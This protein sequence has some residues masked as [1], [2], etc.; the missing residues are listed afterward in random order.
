MFED[1]LYP[2]QASFSHG[3]VSPY[4]FGRVDLQAFGSALRTSRNA[5]IRTEGSWSNRSGT[6]FC[7]PA[8]SATGNGSVIIPFTFNVGQT[9]VIEFGAGTIHLFSQGALINTGT[10]PYAIGDLAKLRYSQSADTLT[11]VHPNYPTYEFKRTDATSFTFLPALYT[12]GPFLQQNPDGVTFVY[13]SAQAGTVTLVASDSIFKAGHVGAL[14]QMTQQD[15]SQIPPWEPTKRMNPLEAGVVAILGQLRRSNGKNYKC[16]GCPNPGAPIAITTGA[17]APDH[18]QGTQSDG[19]GN[20]VANFADAV[21][22]NW[23]YTDSGVGIVLITQF[24]SETQVVG[25]VQA[26]Y[27]GG[28]GLLP[29]AVVGGPQLAV[30]GPWT[31]DG[32]GSTTSFPL[33]TST[34]TDPNLFLVTVGGVYQPPALYSISG[35]N[36]VFLGAPDINVAILVNQITALGQTTYWAFGAFSPDQGYPSAATYYPDRLVLAATP[37]EPVGV[38]ASKT[39]NYHDFGVSNPVVNSDGFTVFLNARQLNAISDLVPLQDIIIGTANI[40]W[41][42]TSGGNGAALGPLAIEAIPQAFLG[43]SPTAAAV[44]YADSMIFAI[45]GGRRIRDLVYQFQFDKY[46]G[47]ELTAYS[48]HLVPFGTQIIKMQ[49]APD[50]WGLLYVLRSDGILLCCTYVREQ[51]MIAWSRWDTQGLVDDIAV[52]PENNNYALYMI[53]RRTINGASVRYV[54]RLSQWETLTP[55]DYQFMDCNLTYDG[56][57]KSAVTM[58]LSGGTTW[59]AGDVGTLNASSATGWAG[60]AA[61]D[62]DLQNQIQLIDAAG[63]CRVQITA[64]LSPA[65]ATVV[66]IDPIPTDLQAVPTL[67]WTFARTKFGGC[68][69]LIGQ[70]VSVVADANAILGQ[71]GVPYIT[72]DSSGFVTL[73]NACGVVC[74][75]LQYYSDLETLALNAQGMETIRQRAKGIPAVYLD[76]TGT[77]GLQTGTDFE[78]MFPIK[79]RAFEP[80]LSPTDVQEGLLSNMM[81]SEFD[82]ESHVCVRQVYPFPVTIRM[83][84]PAVAV[85]EPVG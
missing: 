42:M 21:G 11:V 19:D 72:V 85:G 66:F 46:V 3:E 78:N 58:I 6:E 10:N 45:Y 38:F 65:T 61:T 1:P 59:L 35:T 74:V 51:Q 75:G 22:V 57:N 14:F 27:T 30:V 34:A 20:G 29:L 25:T 80:Y 48:R 4:L 28:P 44:L 64:V 84:I 67:T 8:V 31:F 33:V 13:A 17:V 76:V 43:E 82:S 70:V 40:I 39:S 37:Q 69:H 7:A 68:Q 41:R 49:Y 62:V 52:V 63:Y 9:Y 23:Q 15:L 71:N 53:V 26:N 18:S 2:Q 54:E 50:P 83:V 77:R 24:I 36:L 79:E 16:V 56:R 5:F 32:D 81:Y 47:S 73:P 12:M 60:F 55:Y